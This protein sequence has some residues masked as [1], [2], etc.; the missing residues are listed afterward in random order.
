MT[1]PAETGEELVLQGLASRFWAKVDKSGGADACWLWT[2]ATAGRG[3]GRIYDPRIGHHAAAHRISWELS[4]GPIPDGLF[5]CHRCDNPP[6]VNP[7]H[8]FPGTHTDN[9]RDAGV[10]GRRVFMTCEKH[11]RAKLTP[12]Q[13]QEIRQSPE[14]KRALARRYGI[15]PAQVRNIKNGKS[16]STL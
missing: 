9:M 14:A 3:Y 5:M 16:W 11:G 2:G 4:N 15:D 13:V 12:D 7:A 8:L 1:A 6:C 10:K